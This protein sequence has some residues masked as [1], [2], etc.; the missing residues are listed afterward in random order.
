MKTAGNHRIL[1]IEDEPGVADT[2]LY[3]LKTE[4]FQAAWCQTGTEGLRAISK[5]EID[6]VVLDVGLPDGNGFDFFRE[7]RNQS[8]VPV[9]FLT[10]RS[11]EVDRVLGRPVGYRIGEAPDRDGQYYHY[12]AMWLFALGRF[13]EID[14]AYRTKAIEV[15]K[16]N[17]GIQIGNTGVF[18]TS[19]EGEIKGISDPE[20]LKVSL[21]ITGSFGP[22]ISIFGE[23]AS[24][25]KISGELTFFKGTNAEGKKETSLELTGT[26]TVLEGWV[27][28]ATGSVKIFFPPTCR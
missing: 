14:A 3:A 16:E 6:L 12:L 15:A 13:G 11:E 20:E 8:D 9:I 1:I 21:K 25:V 7:I 2:L 5:E 24:L 18:L 27:G 22:T 4:G 17:P 10:A 26:V 23:T 19:I 28:E